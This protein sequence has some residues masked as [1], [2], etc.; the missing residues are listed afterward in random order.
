MLTYILKRGKACTN[1]GMVNL[2]NIFDWVS[3]LMIK[4][5]IRSSILKLQ[6]SNIFS[7]DVS[8]LIR[9]SLSA[10]L[11]IKNPFNIL[12]YLWLL[13]LERLQEILVFEKY[14]KV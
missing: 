6:I 4:I 5:K 12:G 2:L 1:Y 10:L 9:E 3:N 14:L 11:K 7:R 13:A 8:A